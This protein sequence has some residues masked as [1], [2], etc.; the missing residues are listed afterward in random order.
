M[1]VIAV[2]PQVES[3]MVL[4]TVVFAVAVFLTMAAI[5]RDVLPSLDEK[6]QVYF[7]KWLSSWGTVRFDRA[8]RGAWDQHVRLFPHSRKRV[9]LGCLFLAALLSVITYPLWMSLMTGW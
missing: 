9:L 1:S 3:A 5:V 6:E 8:L 4:V 2:N 7:R